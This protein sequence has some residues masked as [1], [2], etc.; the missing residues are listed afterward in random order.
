MHYAQVR[1]LL[2]DRSGMRGQ[3]Q[4]QAALQQA[5]AHIH[6]RAATTSVAT[7][8]REA[9]AALAAVEA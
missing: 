7:F 5:H 8:M 6:T 3:A 9:G 1:H 4:A 2:L